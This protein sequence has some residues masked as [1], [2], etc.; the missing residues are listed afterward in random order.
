MSQV[1][2]QASISGDKELNSL[3]RLLPTNVQAYAMQPAVTKAVRTIAAAQRSGAPQASG[4]LEQSI[5]ISKIKVMPRKGIVWAAAG[6]RRGFVKTTR[7]G[8]RFVSTKA[9][10]RQGLQTKS[11]ATR[12]AAPTEK[13][14]THVGGKRVEGTH[15]ME[16]GFA[17]VADSVQSQMQADI[18]VGIEKQA[19]KL[20]KKM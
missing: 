18:A 20:I 4:L 2:L 7:G 17:S 15:W 1:T 16:R 13:G 14:F 8:T 12:Y 19:A 5:G 11:T 3:F 9:G 10:K 6:P